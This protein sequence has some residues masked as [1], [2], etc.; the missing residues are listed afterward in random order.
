MSRHYRLGQGVDKNL[1]KA[2]NFSIAAARK[3]HQP[4]QAQV[5]KMYEK[6]LGT[7]K[8]LWKAKYWLKKLAEKGDKRAKERLKKL[9]KR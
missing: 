6:G 4:S 2:Y 3:G 7:K 8:A 9:Q 5:V 1:S